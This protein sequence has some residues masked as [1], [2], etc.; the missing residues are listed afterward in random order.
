MMKRD[1][2]LRLDGLL[3]GARGSLDMIAHYM[4]AN[5]SEEDFVKY[6]SNI[7]KGMAEI[8]EISSDLHKAYPDMVP[9]E[10]K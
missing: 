10:L 5:L 3:N 1:I 6:R 7:A 2:A 8:F 9:D 4:K